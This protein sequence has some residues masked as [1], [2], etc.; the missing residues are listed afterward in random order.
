VVADI[1][2]SFL[3]YLRTEVV[4]R[5]FAT[6]AAGHAAADCLDAAEARQA[7]PTS[8]PDCSNMA[9]TIAGYDGQKALNVCSD[10]SHG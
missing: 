7:R 8:L 3:T 10:Q 2:R 6:I 4:P 9:R 5:P 1:Y